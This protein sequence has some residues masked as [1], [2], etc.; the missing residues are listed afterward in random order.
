MTEI[1]T[2]SKFELRSLFS[3]G[4]ANAVSDG[5][6]SVEPG[7]LGAGNDDGTAARSFTCR[8]R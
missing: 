2:N 5:R 6:S 4:R 7:G 3:K 1:D 8:S